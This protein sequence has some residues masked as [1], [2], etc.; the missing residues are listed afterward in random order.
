MLKSLVLSLHSPGVLR[1][2]CSGWSSSRNSAP[3]ASLEEQNGPWSGQSGMVTVPL[4]PVAVST[5]DGFAPK[6]NIPFISGQLG[7]E[8]WF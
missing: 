3:S 2:R 1:G 7:M 8:L 6:Q 5:A 4:D